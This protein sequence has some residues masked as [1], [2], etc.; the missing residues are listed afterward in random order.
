MK[1]HEY[2]AKELLAE[3]GATVPRGI[4]AST[5]AE[6]QQAFDRLGGPVVLK[7]QVHA[8][9]RG[10]GHFKDSGKDW[11]GVKFVKSRDEAGA[12]AEV[13]LRYPLVTKQTGPEGQRVSRVLVVEAQSKIAREVYVGMVLD[14]EIGL[15][16]LMA[17]AEGG[18]EIEEVA[19]RHPEKILKTA[20]DPDAGLQPFQ[21]RRVAYDLGFQGEQV[22]QAE[23][24]LTALARVFLDKNCSLAEINPL[25]VTD[26][27]AVQVLDAKMTFDDNAL[28]RHPDVERLRD[29]TEE[30]PAEVRA[31]KAG[32]TYISMTGNIGCLVNGAGLAM[33][34][35]DIIKYH[36]GEPA[37]FLDVGGGVTPEGAIE[38]FRIILSDPRVRGILVNIFGGI[39]KCDLIA[40]ALVKAGREVGF[41]VPVVVRLEGTNVDRARQI[42]AAARSE[43]PMIE[44][45]GG[46]TEAA[47]KVVGAAR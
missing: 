27:G 12:A 25:V 5:P 13:M 38:A 10:K 11:G 8:G 18:V 41:K 6:A 42:L 39:A 28:F 47:K 15:P 32:L 46:L 31:G 17:C 23:K 14:R 20:V 19:A 1:I 34:T 21:A 16:V 4:V 44:P 3:A 33:S 29:L 22:P 7:A 37:N 30:N 2:Q 35:M 45:A 36:G 40:E 43:L 9:G 26:A 24:V